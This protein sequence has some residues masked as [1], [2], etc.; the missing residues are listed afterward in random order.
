[1]YIGSEG[2]L[3]FVSV[4]IVVITSIATAVS[5]EES[6][7]NLVYIRAAKWQDAIGA[8]LGTLVCSRVDY[9]VHENVLSQLL[10]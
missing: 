6:C 8:E 2:E 1:M 10:S 5:D 9:A 4:A 7:H 3:I